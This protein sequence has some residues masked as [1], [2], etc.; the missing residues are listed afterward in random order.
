MI[1]F[2]FLPPLFCL[3]LRRRTFTQI[4]TLALFPKVPTYWGSKKGICPFAATGPA[5]PNNHPVQTEIIT[6]H[7]P[8]IKLD[9]TPEDT[10]YSPF[11]D[12]TS[13]NFSQYFSIKKGRPK[14]ESLSRKTGLC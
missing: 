8:V 3:V 5:T 2:Y 9:S 14:D 12:K 6:E 10:F 11:P 7:P 1:P 13:V 4:N